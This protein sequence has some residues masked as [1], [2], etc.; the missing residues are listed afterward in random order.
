MAPRRSIGE[1][2]LEE[3]GGLTVPIGPKGRCDAN[4]SVR[5]HAGSVGN[6]GQELRLLCKRL[7]NVHKAIIP[8]FETVR[9]CWKRQVAR[10][11]YREFGFAAPGRV[12]P[13]P[14]NWP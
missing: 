14:P 13:R 9:R 4:D 1:Y 8:R 7:R 12:T 6:G 5:Q 10:F 2:D 11:V 3:D